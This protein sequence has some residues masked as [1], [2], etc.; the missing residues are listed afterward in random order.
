AQ[1]AAMVRPGGRLYVDIMDAD[2][3]A[4][5]EPDHS[6]YPPVRVGDRTVELKEMIINDF[7]ARTRV[8]KST[9]MVD[10]VPHEFSRHSHKID[11]GELVSMLTGAGLVDVRAESM[12]SERYQVFTARRPDQ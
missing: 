11:H 12:P 8:W 5:R 3:L 10:G 9:L 2:T 6:V 4:R 7:E 1:F